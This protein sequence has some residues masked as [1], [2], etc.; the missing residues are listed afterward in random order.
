MEADDIAYIPDLEKKR[1]P[2][3]EK[4]FL[5]SIEEVE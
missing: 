5:V 2:V 4:D 1:A 3:N